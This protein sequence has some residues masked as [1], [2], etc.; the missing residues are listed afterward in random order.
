MKTTTFGIITAGL[1]ALTDILKDGA[2]LED[3]KT[4][5]VP[6]GLAIWAYFTEDKKS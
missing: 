3:W 1:Y 2:K 5:V 6:V 4:W